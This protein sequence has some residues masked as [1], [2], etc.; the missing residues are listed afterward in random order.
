MPEDRTYAKGM[1]DAHAMIRWIASK[2]WLFRLIVKPAIKQLDRT[3]CEQVRIARERET[4]NEPLVDNPSGFY[5]SSC[6][7]AGLMHCSDPANC[8]EMRRMKPMPV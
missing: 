2:H 7:D 5:C 1:I 3:M 8:G 6:R 4:E